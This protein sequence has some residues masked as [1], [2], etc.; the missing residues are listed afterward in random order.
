MRWSPQRATAVGRGGS[1]LLLAACGPALEAPPIWAA[2]LLVLAV[3]A[4]ARQRLAC[5]PWL[6]VIDYAACFLCA[7]VWPGALIGLTLPAFEALRAGR[8]LLLMP[9]ALPFLPPLRPMI[10]DPAVELL[11]A[12]GALCAA[13]AYAGALLRGWGRD[14]RRYRSEADSERYER[15]SLEELRG[16]LLLAGAHS[17]R[18]A[19]LAERSRIASELHDHA[20]HD[21][22]AAALAFRAYAELRKSGDADAAV[23]FDEALRR[24]EDGMGALRSTVHAMRP[25]AAYGLERLHEICD[26]FEAC[27]I[28]LR[29]DGDTGRLP[30]HF[31]S[32]LEPAVKEALTNVLRHADARRV[33][34]ALEVGPQIVRLQVHNDVQSPHRVSSGAAHAPG[35]GLRN[36]RQRARAVGGHVSVRANEAGFLLVCVLP[37][38]EQV[39]QEKETD[40]EHAHTDRR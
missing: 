27:P 39:S 21:L 35:I 12:V 8:P 34:A 2:L 29:V 5:P 14:A 28:V 26:T 19:E 11:L 37:L 36:L 25:I 10:G 22:T 1:L 9:L 40:D 33:E 20:G 32:V 16:E 38:P 4:A 24:L 6:A 3:A 15:L 31:W 30:P 17:A 13:C 18:T 23:W 7:S